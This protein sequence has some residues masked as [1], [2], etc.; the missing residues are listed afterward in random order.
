MNHSDL[1]PLL[2]SLFDLFACDGI[3]NSIIEDCWKECLEQLKKDGRSPT[4]KRIFIKEWSED[5]TIT[6]YAFGILDDGYVWKTK[7]EE[8]KYFDEL[9][10]ENPELNV[11]N[12][13]TSG[14]LNN[15]V[16]S[17][18]SY[19]GPDKLNSENDKF[20]DKEI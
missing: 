9:S 19:L 10:K 14:E 2:P 15:E 7:F 6:K 16:E 12:W 17:W 20:I 8:K 4:L 1:Y 11:K 13:N 5:Q 18:D 3:W